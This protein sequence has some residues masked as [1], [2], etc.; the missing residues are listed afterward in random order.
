MSEAENQEMHQ[1]FLAMKEM[2][3]KI[4]GVIDVGL[5]FKETNG[6]FTKEISYVV[7]VEEKIDQDKLPPEH[8]IPK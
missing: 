4:P 2:L 3:K 5:G 1:K 7:Y 8:V 6:E